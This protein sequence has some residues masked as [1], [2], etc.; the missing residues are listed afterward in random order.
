[1]EFKGIRYTLRVRAEREQW[2]VAIHPEGVEMAQKVITGP[3]ESAELLAQSMIKKWLEKRL[4][5][6]ITVP[7]KR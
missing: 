3:R 5:Q 4:P 7:E 6:N 2:S 1:M